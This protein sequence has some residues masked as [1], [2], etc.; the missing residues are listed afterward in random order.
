MK[1]SIL[2]I[3]DDLNVFRDIKDA[4]SDDATDVYCTESVAGA[5]ETIQ[6]REY[7]LA[8]IAAQLSRYQDIEVIRTIRSTQKIPIIVLADRL[9]TMDE[10]MLFQAGANACIETSVDLAVCAAQAI[11][12]IHLYLEAREKEPSYQPKVFGR[13]LIINTLYRQIIVDGESLDLT[14]TEYEIFVCLANR[15]YQIWSPT[16]LYC[17]VWNDTLGLTGENTV[18]THIGNLKKKLAKR[19]KSYIQNSRGVGYKFVPPLQ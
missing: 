1:K 4:L 17:Y 5:I 19:G 18:K 12:L 3:D 6:K 14:R 7:C 10:V 11:S 16:Q 8:V 9:T 2:V 13:E 15:P